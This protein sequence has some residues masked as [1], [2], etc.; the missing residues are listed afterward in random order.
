MNNF[1][2][3]E[4]NEIKSLNNI[5]ILN[6]SNNTINKILLDDKNKNIINNLSKL[7]DNL[8]KKIIIEILSNIYIDKSYKLK[9]WKN[10][11]K[12]NK[13]IASEL[14]NDICNDKYIQKIN[15]LYFIINYLNHVKKESIDLDEKNIESFKNFIE[16]CHINKMLINYFLQNKELINKYIK[17]NEKTKKLKEILNDKEILTIKKEEIKISDFMMENKKFFNQIK[18]NNKL[19]DDFQL[20]YNYSYPT[21]SKNEKNEII[22]KSDYSYYL[23]ISF[24]LG[25]MAKKLNL[26]TIN[27]KLVYRTIG[28]FLR[29]DIFNMDYYIYDDKNNISFTFIADKNEINKIEKS[30]H[31]FIFNVSNITN[32]INKEDCVNFKKNLKEK[33]ENFLSYMKLSNE[34]DKIEINKQINKIKI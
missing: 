32:N 21:L 17:D 11:I 16:K 9:I 6:L 24:N 29:K 1:T 4:I 3:D 31:Y 8:C 2:L 20:M 22:K 5:D 10:I 13:T 23:N 7:N 12:N 27:L 18:A 25:L 33:V 14:F 26:N 19:D 28:C 30:M 34:I 15:Q